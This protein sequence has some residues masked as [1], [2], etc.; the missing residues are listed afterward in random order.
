MAAL[1]LICK[2]PSLG[3]SKQ[4][5]AKAMGSAHTLQ[6]AQALLDCALDDLG[7]WQQT[8][9]IAYENKQD[10]PF[11][12]KRCPS[13]QFIQQ[14]HGNLGIRINSI[15]KELRE[16]A[17]QQ[18]MYIGSDCPTLTIQQLNK[19]EVALQTNDFVF[20]DSDD[21]G[22]VLMANK[23]P[24]PKLEQLPWS[25]PNLGSELKSACKAHGKVETV[26]CLSDLDTVEDIAPTAALLQN[27]NRASR[28]R[29][30]ARLHQHITTSPA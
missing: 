4:R 25:Q 8:Q 21:G 30:L 9:I 24:W 29:L 2:K 6:I 5:L 20:V 7:H 13:A 1:T 11:F 28:Q 18:I 19:V 27:D 14:G 23:K 26:A 3:H 10:L 12:S 17:H 22:V 16:S 15:D